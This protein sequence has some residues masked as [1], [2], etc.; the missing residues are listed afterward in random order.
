MRRDE[1]GLR[2]GAYEDYIASSQWRRLRRKPWSAT[3]IAVACVVPRIALEVHHRKYPPH[4]RWDLDCLDHLT[5]LCSTCHETVTSMLRARRYAVRE[6]RVTDTSCGWA[7]PRRSSVSAYQSLSFRITGVSPLLMHNG[8]LVD[9]LNPHS[10]SIAEVTK[11]RKKTDADQLEVGR[12]EFFGGLYLS[13]GEPCI[14]AEMLEATLIKG[15][16]KEEKRGPAAKAG[17]L[18]RSN[19]K[20]EYDGPRDPKDL[21]KDERFR[22]RVAAKGAQARSTR[23]RPRFDGWA[24]DIVVKFLP[25]MLNGKEVPYFLAGGWRADRYW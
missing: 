2:K 20:L 6:L 22:L 24:A 18:A 4:G 14:P 17:L 11:K 3:D 21:W 16:M 10:Q 19:A 7:R 13:G 23:T 25:S 5:T 9:P 1:G 12:R 15:A 8:Q